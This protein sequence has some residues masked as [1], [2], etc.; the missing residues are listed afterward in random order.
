MPKVSGV[1]AY[2]D[3]EGQTEWTYQLQVDALP[4]NAEQIEA[5]ARVV[6][7]T[8]N[9]TAQDEVED[10]GDDWKKEGGGNP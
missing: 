1:I 4:V 6:M 9:Q 3:A 7:R 10:G 5:V 2:K 8:L